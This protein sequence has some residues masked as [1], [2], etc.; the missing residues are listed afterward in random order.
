MLKI[1]GFAL[2]VAST[3]HRKG[4]AKRADKKSKTPRARTGPMRRGRAGAGPDGR[5]AAG[6]AARA[7]VRGTSRSAMYASRKG[8]RLARSFRA[9]PAAQKQKPNREHE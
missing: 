5:L 7:R 3:I 4:K 8:H 1:S 6:P 9:S 2:K